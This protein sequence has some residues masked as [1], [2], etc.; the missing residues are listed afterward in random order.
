MPLPKGT[1]LLDG[2]EGTFT[3]M[4][5]VVREI[6]FFPDKRVAATACSDGKARTFDA[7]TGTLLCTF[8]NPQ[9]IMMQLR[10]I[11]CIE[12]IGGDIFVSGSGKGDVTVWCASTWNS[13]GQARIEDEGGVSALAAAGPSNFSAGMH[14]GPLHFF[15]HCDGEKI[16]EE[17]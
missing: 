1:V 9:G 5:L 4:G 8:E 13:L 17:F 3:Q 6:Q 12:V 11:F 2:I 10:H 16:K 14:D 7:D 15:Y